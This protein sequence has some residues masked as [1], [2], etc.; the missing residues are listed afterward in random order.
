METYEGNFLF[1][2][3]PASNLG[4]LYSV[5]Q[6]QFNVTSALFFDLAMLISCYLMFQI[7]YIFS[8]DISFNHKKTKLILSCLCGLGFFF[9]IFPYSKF[10]WIHRF[11]AAFVVGPLWALATLF[12]LEVKHSISTLAFI[13]YQFILQGSILSYAFLYFT[14]LPGADIAQK[15]GIASLMI[16]LWSTTR[17]PVR[18]E[19]ILKEYS[20][21]H[22][23]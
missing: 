10:L 12:S 1:W 16:V 8:L 3:D 6:Q 23:N 19:Q 14:G 2:K 21:I 18:A 4:I 9:I 20:F 13:F 17:I 5:S 7:A 22:S 11:G 15:F